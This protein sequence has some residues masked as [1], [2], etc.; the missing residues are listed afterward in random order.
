M[1]ERH[2][3]RHVRRC[4]SCWF[5]LQTSIFVNPHPLG[6]CRSAESRRTRVSNGLTTVLSGPPKY[7]VPSSACPPA[8]VHVRPWMSKGSFFPQSG[9]PFQGPWADSF[10]AALPLA[11]GATPSDWG[12]RLVSCEKLALAKGH[13]LHPPAECHAPHEVSAFE[14][15]SALDAA[16]ARTCGM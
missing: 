5:D 7:D 1:P 2:E 14:V 10:P 15:S 3:E 8:F 11:T 13:S 9:L 16:P 4:A 6:L 12:E